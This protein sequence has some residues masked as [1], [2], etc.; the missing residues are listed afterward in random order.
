MGKRLLIALVLGMGLMWVEAMGQG[1]L[2]SVHYKIVAQSSGDPILRV[3][4][5]PSETDTVSI[6]LDGSPSAE[7][8]L[9]AVTSL[10]SHRTQYTWG[11]QVT[12]V[13]TEIDSVNTI[14]FSV[15]GGNGLATQF[16]FIKNKGGT[17]IVW[18]QQGVPVWVLMADGTLRTQ[19]LMD[20]IATSLIAGLYPT[21]D[22]FSVT[23]S[24]TIGAIPRKIANIEFK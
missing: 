21:P 5:I 22:Y 3:W 18:I 13:K 4:C 1:N 17:D 24:P 23:I 14:K 7:Y 6:I 20:Y 10:A 9:A 8:V 19:R 11:K 15:G 12:I 2:P 16:A